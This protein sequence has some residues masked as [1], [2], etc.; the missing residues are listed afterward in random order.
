MT[1]TEP[2]RVL[3]DQGTRDDVKAIYVHDR[4]ME[5]IQ[6]MIAHTEKIKV[7]FGL[8]KEYTTAALSL[9]H[10]LFSLFRLGFAREC[11]VTKDGDLSLYVQEGTAFVYGIVW[12][13]DRAYDGTDKE[14]IAGDWSLHS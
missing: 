2:A 13:R 14:G 10:A 5:T 11:L 1:F 8:G 6:A 4:A 12:F 3:A 9:H 7:T